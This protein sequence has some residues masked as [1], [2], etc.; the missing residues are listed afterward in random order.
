MA[1]ANSFV[2]NHFPSDCII[3]GV[4]AHIYKEDVTWDRSIEMTYEEWKRKN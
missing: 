3:L 2:N 1:G 4:P